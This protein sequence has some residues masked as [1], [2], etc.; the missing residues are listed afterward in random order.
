MGYGGE[1][2]PVYFSCV[3]K[4]SVYTVAAVTGQTNSPLSPYPNHPQI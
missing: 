2:I 1:F 4:H 3:N